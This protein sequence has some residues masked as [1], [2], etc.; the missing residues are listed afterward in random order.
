MGIVYRAEHR[1]LARTVALKMLTPKLA[2]DPDFRER[3]LRESRVA[4]QLDH[5]SIVTVYDAGDVSG[6]LYI[7]MRFVQGTAPAHVLKA[8]GA[9]APDRALSIVGQVAAALDAAH[10]SHL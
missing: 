7:A 5:P 4:A 9:L 10:A 6:T 8:E 2:A 1:H 3:F